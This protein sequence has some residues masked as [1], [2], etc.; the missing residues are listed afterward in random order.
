MDPARSGRDENRPGFQLMLAEVP[1]IKPTVLILWKTDRLARDQAMAAIAKRAIRNAGCAIEFV[2][3]TTPDDTPEGKLIESFFDSLAEFYSA[4]LS[5]NTTRGMRYNAEAAKFNGHRV[6]GYRKSEDGRYEIDPDTAP[7]VRR[8]FNMY[9]DGKSMSEIIEYLDA[10]GIRSVNGNRMT[11]NSLRHI[12]HND[13]YLGIYRYADI[14]IPGGMPPI[15]D[16]VLFDIVQQRFKENQR[17]GPHFANEADESDVPRYW[18]TGKL[19]CGKCRESMHGLCGTGKHGERHY[20]YACKNHRKRRCSK[21]NVR[22]SLIEARVIE[23]LRNILADTENRATLAVD[24]SSYYREHYLDTRY[25]DGL[26][27]ELSSVNKAL[28]NLVKA[29][30]KGLPFTDSI[31]DR[32]AE[33][34]ERKRALSEAIEAEE[35]RA[36]VAQDE[37]SIRAY[38]EKY[39]SADFDDE[40]TRDSILNYFVDKI[41][42]YD[43]GRLVITG[44]YSDLH[45]ELM[46]EDLCGDDD[47]YGFVYDQSLGTGFAYPADGGTSF[48]RSRACAS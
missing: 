31:A 23:I 16:Q 40:E 13:R 4:Q 7:I 41:Y 35:A 11:I 22:K 29:I 21:R 47:D 36:R 27:G 10:Q 15:V 37:A 1:K 14:E 33:H 34:E 28:N 30:E 24:I 39:S 9:A 32:L 26:K 38:F 25:L 42:L 2:A 20:Y 48:S 8:I 6:F 46:F 18:L 43:D 45:H 17:K 3:E 44:W 12:L 5:V 19:Y